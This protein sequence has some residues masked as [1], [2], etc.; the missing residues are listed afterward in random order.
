[1]HPICVTQQTKLSSLMRNIT[2]F[3]FLLVPFLS[4]VG[5]TTVGPSF[6]SVPVEQ[7]PQGKG[8]VYVYRPKTIAMAGVTAE[9]F[10]DDRPIVPIRNNGY[11]AIPLSAG[12][13][14]I[15]HKWKANSSGPFSKPIKRQV[16]V[17]NKGSVYFR[18]FSVA[19]IDYEH[20]NYRETVTKSQ[21]RW[22]FEEVNSAAAIPEIVNC[23]QVP[24]ASLH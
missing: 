24:L 11:V 16:V 19:N 10:V 18:I 9:I 22:A 23:K 8:I 14:T 7:I 6:T 17:K 15:T 5:C 21:I 12:V 13:H 1:M 20:P 2:R 3:V 4:M